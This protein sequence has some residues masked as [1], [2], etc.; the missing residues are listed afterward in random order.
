MKKLI[1]LI[2]TGILALTACCGLVGCKK[3]PNK[4]MIVSNL[5]LVEE[6]YGIA[7]KK[8]NEALV[9]K[10]NEALI[11]VANDKLVSI[12]NT[13]GLTSELAV[14]SETVNPLADATDS[15][16]N[17]LVARN[18]VVIGYTIFAPIAYEVVNDVPT[19]GFDIE[20]AKAV[21]NYL[22]EK[23]STN[24]VVEFFK[25]DWNAKEALLEGGS[26]DLV[27]NGLTI[28]DS[29]LNQMCISVPYLNNKQVAV[30]MS[31]NAEKFTTIASMANAVTGAEDGSAGEEQISLKN[32]GKEYIKCGS[33]L[34]AFNKLK[35]GTLEVIIIDSVMA[36]YYISLEK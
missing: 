2:L 6:Q 29:R 34:E 24:I 5:V 17:D 31:K 22:N 1:T 12:A 30:I 19:K 25:I 11:A 15:S 7:A 28:T 13:Y 4:P 27:W 36:N 26:I 14:T 32:I 20:L 8:G 16:W 23:Y 9:S 21:F 33:Q 10:V 3:E 35:T 18:K